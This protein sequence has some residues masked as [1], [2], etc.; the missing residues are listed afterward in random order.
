MD[1]GRIQ[2]ALRERGIDGW[3]FCDFHNR[4]PIAYRVLGLDFG[5]FTS[6]RWFYYIPAD[7]EPRRL[8]HSVEKTKLDSLPGRKDVYLPWE[9][10]HGLLREIL[11]DPGKNIAMQYSP[12]NNIPYVAM[13]DAG[14]VAPGWPPPHPGT[15]PQCHSSHE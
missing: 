10:L 7:G 13:V 14:T 4:D 8:V 9:Q 1:V 12:L 5:K 6:R 3:L 15:Y 2:E 11:G